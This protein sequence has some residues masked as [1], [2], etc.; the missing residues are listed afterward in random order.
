MTK[1]KT[2]DEV[3]I[4]NGGGWG[5]YSLYYGDSIDKTFII[6]NVMEK[7]STSSKPIYYSGD[8]KW[9]YREDN[10]VLVNN[11]TDLPLFKGVK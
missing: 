4:I 3:R 6:T 1:F 11:I 8:S 9:W 10:L 2:G 7:S 5:N